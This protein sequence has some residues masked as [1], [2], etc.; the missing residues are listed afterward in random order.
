MSSSDTAS[1][2]SSELFGIISGLWKSGDHS[3]LT[4]TCGSEIYNESNTRRV[5][6]H[7]DNPA[8]VKRMLQFCYGIDY[9]GV[10]GPDEP[11]SQVTPA[12]LNA[13]IYVLADKYDVKGL[14]S[15]AAAKFTERMNERSSLTLNLDLISFIYSNTTDSNSTLRTE[16][17]RRAHGQWKKIAAEPDIKAVIA[18]FPEFAIEML[19][20]QPVTIRETQKPVHSGLCPGCGATNAWETS[21]VK[22]SC[23]RYKNLAT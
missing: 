2:I 7:E 11:G 9:D 14:K 20:S 10:M 4:I 16:T 17:V 6:L 13:E 15:V 8:A 21:K 12:R 5:E 22:C 19:D 18:E 3:D 1:T 23:G